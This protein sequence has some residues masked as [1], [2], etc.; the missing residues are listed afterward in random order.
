MS[1]QSVIDVT[2]LA[3]IESM[4]R[5]AVAD[6]WACSIA[7]AFA[8]MFA[9]SETVFYPMPVSESG[10]E[11]TTNLELI[12]HLMRRDSDAISSVPYSTQQLREVEHDDVKACLKNL[13][14]WAGLNRQF[15][16]QWLSLHQQSWVT[17]WHEERF[18]HL[19]SFDVERYRDDPDVVRCAAALQVPPLAIIYALDLVLR[20]PILG[21][22][23]GDQRPYFAH[24]LR[25]R[26][27]IP[28]VEADKN[29]P[30]KQLGSVAFSE[31]IKSFAH[32]LTLDEYAVLLHKLRAMV[33]E[34]GLQD[35]REGQV[36]TD[37]LREIA[38]R[39]EFPPRLRNFKE[40]LG[41]AGAAMGAASTLLGGASSVGVPMTM[42]RSIWRGYLPREVGK[43][44]WLRWALTWDIEKESN[45]SAMP[46]RPKR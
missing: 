14:V 6:P 37:V 33:R 2:S 7:G 30:P 39:M 11:P 17:N 10:I 29:V 19:Y 13:K 31:T 46:Q 4:K 32:Q 1:I 9:F 34:Y 27:D 24:P 35:A 3:G 22:I 25:C 23:A 18:P 42:A 36:S 15:A 44:K 26:F 40:A 28:G 41:A 21:E 8:D 38:V 43:V 16:V 5:G 20:Y 12:S 45:T